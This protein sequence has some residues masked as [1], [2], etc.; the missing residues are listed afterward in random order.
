M[1]E[2]SRVT[3][4]SELP[5]SQR[6]SASVCEC[7]AIAACRST[8]VREF[9]V[10][11]TCTT[12]KWHLTLKW[13]PEAAV[14]ACLLTFGKV[15]ILFVKDHAMKPLP[16]KVIVFEVGRSKKEERRR[17][18]NRR[19]SGFLVMRYARRHCKIKL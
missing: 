18:R 3:K 4:V 10:T 7:S 12:R 11:G 8:H 1:S 6:E 17:W 9:H 14:F 16:T 15:K 2:R 13:R 5:E 19:F